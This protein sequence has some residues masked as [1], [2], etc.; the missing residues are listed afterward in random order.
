MTAECLQ[1]TA[2]PDGAVAAAEL[3]APVSWR[4]DRRVRD[5]RLEVGDKGLILRGRAPTYYAKQLAQHAVMQTTRLSILANE[6][7]VSLSPRWDERS[8]EGAPGEV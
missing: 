3:E 8:F 5:F 1:T 6:I 4:L 2:D 7:E